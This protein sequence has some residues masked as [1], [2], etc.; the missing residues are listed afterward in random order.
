MA[1]IGRPRRRWEDIK[2]D[3]Q[4]VELG[5]GGGGMD[6]LELAQDGNR[7]RAFVNTVMNLRVS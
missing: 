1:C 5:W 4:E 3:H 6:W 2:M 7:W